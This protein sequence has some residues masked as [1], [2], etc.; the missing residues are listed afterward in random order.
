M[1]RLLLILILTFS[2]QSWTKADDISE[3]EIEGMS[4]GDS[5]LD[6][7]SEKEIKQNYSSSQYPNKEFVLYYFNDTS[8]FETY[9]AVTVAVKANDKNYI[10][11]DIGGSIYFAKNFDKCL[12]KMEEVVR[13]LNQIFSNAQTGSGKNNHSFDKTGKTIQYYNIYLLNS[14]DNSQVVCLNWSN[15]LEKNGRVDE[16]NLSLGLKEYAD[17][18]DTRAY[19]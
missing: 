13:E 4:I 14:G 5:L 19:K 7:F 10:I 15:E 18:V 16:L 12:S 17:F 3:F 6:H 8:K 11:Y 2:F 1:K 9:E